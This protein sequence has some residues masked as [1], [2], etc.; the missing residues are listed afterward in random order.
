MNI[1]GNSNVN[2]AAYDRDDVSLRVTGN[3]NQDAGCFKTFNQKMIVEGDFTLSDGTFEV[4]GNDA[5]INNGDTDAAQI[6]E[7]L[8][9]KNTGLTVL[10]NMTLQN[11]SK[12]SMTYVTSHVTVNGDFTVSNNISNDF[13]NGV[14]E[15]KGD[16]LQKESE[17]NFKLISE[18]DEIEK[19]QLKFVNN[20]IVVLNGSGRQKISFETPSLL[21]ADYSLKTRRSQFATLK[22]TKSFYSYEF[23]NDLSKERV[24]ENLIE[25]VYD[26]FYKNNGEPYRIRKHLEIPESRLELVN[27]NGYIYAIGGVDEKNIVHNDIGRYDFEQ[28]AWTRAGYLNEKRMDFAATAVNNDIYVFGGHNGSNVT[29]KI[30]VI[31]S[32]GS[33]KTVELDPDSEIIKRK[34]HEAVYYNGKIYIMGGESAEG[35]TLNTVEVFDPVSKTV[36]VIEPM[37]SERKNFGAALYFDGSKFVIAAAGGENSSGILKSVEFYDFETKTWKSQP[38]MNIPR[39]GFGLEF[40]MA[41]LYAVGGV[42]SENAGGVIYAGTTEGLGSA[43]WENIQNGNNEDISLSTPRGFFG[44]AVAYNSIFVAGG[45]TPDKTDVFEQFMPSYVPGARFKGN[46]KGLNGDFTQEKTDLSFLDTVQSFSLDRV[47]N[48]Q[49]KD[50]ESSFLGNGWKF[51][52]E[53]SVKKMSENKGTVTATYLNVRDNPWGNIVGGLEKGTVFDITGTKTD[54]NGKVWYE[55]AG[56]WYVSSGYVDKVE[57]NVVEVTYPDGIKDYFTQDKNNDKVYKGNFGTYNKFEFL[58]DKTC[59]LTTKEQVK[60]TYTLD[61]ELF[62]NTAISDR[63]GNV[64]KISHSSGK[65]VIT[66]N[67]DEK[68]TVVKSGNTVTATDGFERTVTYELSDGHL[69][70]VTN[71]NGSITE[72]KYDGDDIIEITEKKNSSD[73]GSVLCKVEY[74]RSGRIYTYT[75]AEKNKSYN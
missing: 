44:S 8:P 65:V 19:S 15:V 25:P 39:K 28:N 35:E 36:E 38:E 53:S 57:N 60:Y 18:D 16:F 59:V 74:D 33:V 48:S 10:G 27:S 37:G 54:Y 67:A 55:I 58:D 56:K 9:G 40:L 6:Q 69:K 43:G 42:T 23:A 75:D 61:G 7:E 5:E 64:T 70:S 20:H 2:I 11:S 45:E 72:Y 73:S 21:N 13:R 30:E 49:L 47:F 71:T 31:S 14:L 51:S 29:D 26:D 62:R 22:L 46:T 1:K 24:F 17:V 63:Y 12:F 41:K 66:N 34:S 4:M 32:S 50:E 52:F 3:Y 68:I